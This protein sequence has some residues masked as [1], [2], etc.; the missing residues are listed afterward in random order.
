MNGKNLLWV[1]FAL[2]MFPSS[3]KWNLKGPSFS[4]LCV[5]ARNYIWAMS[6]ST[7]S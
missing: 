1:L 5:N 6:R 4:K 3:Y 7:P 2:P